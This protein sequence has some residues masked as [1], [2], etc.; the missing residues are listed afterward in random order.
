MDSQ[1][2]YDNLPWDMIVSAL[3]GALSPEED[4]QFREWLALSPD[5]QQ[6]YHQLQQIWKDKMADYIIYREADEAKAWEA[7]QQSLGAS[8]PPHPSVGRR[9]PMIRRWIAVA[10]VFLLA[11][12]AGWWYLSRMNAPILYETALEQKKISLPDG[13][14]VLINPQT[15]IRVSREYNKAG[16]TV[17]LAA[18]EA[19]FDVSHQ[20]QLPFIVD[21]DVASIKDIGTDFTVQRSKDSI[22]VT[23]TGG[24][25]AFIKK[26][27]GE[28]RELSAGSSLTYYI[29]DHRFGDTKTTDLA[30]TGA[31][32]TRFENTP[33]SDVI[34]ALQ[35]ISGRQI[36]L[37]DVL[38]GQKRL[39]VDLEGETFDNA[40]K[41]ICTSL[42]LEYTEKNGLYIL[43]NKDSLI[44]NH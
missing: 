27:T 32:H 33:L 30:M 12:G 36:S 17:I 16:R 2:T 26:E 22:M 37:D 20:P 7:L 29:P 39:T 34:A 43:K 35:K 42:N 25:V 1:P 40:I 38:L 10:A 5:N 44:H 21:L 3:Q 18:G 11:V 14:I 8:G 31:S 15:R 28:S 24:K 4:L 23:V 41:I 6:K 13:S 9:I 19:H